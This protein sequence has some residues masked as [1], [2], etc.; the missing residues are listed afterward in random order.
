MEKIKIVK[1]QGRYGFGKATASVQTNI[2]DSHH[3]YGAG[4]RKSQ[5]AL[6]RVML[7]ATETEAAAFNG[8]EVELTY[9]GND[10]NTSLP[11][12]Q[13]AGAVKARN[14]E[15]MKGKVQNLAKMMKV[16]QET[17]RVEG[18]DATQLMNFIMVERSNSR[19]YR[20]NRNVTQNAPVNVHAL[21]LQ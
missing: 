2:I 15:R 11:M 10:L 7:A 5:D 3:I 1:I 21:T 19:N 4:G 20:N 17:A 8:K 16:A 18:V 12:Y 6:V 13:I 14:H 9:A